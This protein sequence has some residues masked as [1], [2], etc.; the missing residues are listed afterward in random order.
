MQ[1]LNQSDILELK[2]H[3]ISKECAEAQIENFKNGFPYLHIQSAA[4]IPNNGIKVVTP[5]RA[6]ELIDLWEEYT[7][8]DH[9]IVKFVPAS[10]AATRMFKDLFEYLNRNAPSEPDVFV[11]NLNKHIEAFAFFDSLNTA[12][13]NAT[14]KDIHQHI[15]DNEF[16]PII[17]ML[18]KE[19]GLNYGQ[20]PKGALLFHKYPKQNRTPFE[21]HLV[22]AA[23]YASANGKANIHFTV[24]EEHQGLFEELKAR[25]QSLYS[26]KYGTEI[27]ISFSNQ[28]KATD[29]IAADMNNDPFRE[30]GKLV[31]RPAGHGALIQNLN[32]IDSDI[33]FIKN[34]DN[35]SIEDKFPTAIDYKKILAGK[36]IQLQH[37]VYSCMHQ[38]AHDDLKREQL[39][40]IANFMEESFSM[41]V[42][43]TISSMSDREAQA[44][45][46]TKLNRPIRVCGMIQNSG[47][48]GGGPYIIK[49]DNNE[50]SLQILES[51]QIDITNPA[52]KEKMKL[53]THFNPVDLVCAVRDYAGN[54]FDLTRY[55]DPK[56]GFISEKT[57]NGVKLK[58]LEVPGLWNGAMSEW[59]TM[60]IEVPLESFNPV[61]TVLDLLRTGHQ[62]QKL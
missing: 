19:D 35:V 12:L 29:T 40:R 42:P 39:N 57:K 1:T 28:K 56:T 50:T 18:L 47:E 55:I 14:G 20:L 21:E 53:S 34:I 38:L 24:S 15:T 8:E 22:E 49:N 9:R 45:I 16:A 11:D 7:K 33:I 52:E 6:K 41:N 48:P 46:I 30:N 31:F 23:K 25:F 13:I 4:T 37:E 61:K 51:S 26:S 36:L 59:N 43:E 3:G 10:G 62:Y 60:F 54:K 2:A 5:E 27:S 44:Y 32:D 58:A 17:D